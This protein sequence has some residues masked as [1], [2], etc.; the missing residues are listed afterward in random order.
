MRI[1]AGRIT[2]VED[3]AERRQALAVA[4]LRGDGAPGPS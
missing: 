3:Y 2:R 4:A 1:D